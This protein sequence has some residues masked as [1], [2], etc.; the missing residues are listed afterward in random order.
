VYDEKIQVNAHFTKQRRRW[1]AA[2]FE[3]FIRYNTF[4]IQAL[5]KGNFDFC[6]KVFQ[7]VFPPRI[8]IVG[9]VIFMTTFAMLIDR[10]DMH[11]W[12]IDLLL[13]VLALFIATPKWLLNRKLIHA[14]FSLPSI[15]LWMFLNLFN[16]KGA[17][18]QFIHTPHGK[19]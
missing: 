17:N 8:L 14:L 2:Q 3:H 6:D 11:K 15:F 18:K 19:L 12:L 5:L 4:F 7:M 13:L 10:V 9:G 1:M 16:L